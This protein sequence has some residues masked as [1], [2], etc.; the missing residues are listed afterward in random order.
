M[1]FFENLIFL[2]KLKKEID[3]CTFFVDKKLNKFQ[4][5]E[6][7]NYFFLNIDKKIEVGK[8]RTYNL[9]QKNKAGYLKIRKKVFVN[10]KFSSFENKRL[11]TN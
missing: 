9:K 10:L 1:I 5:R 7:I 11:L 6:E 8:I 4:I 2:N 3:V